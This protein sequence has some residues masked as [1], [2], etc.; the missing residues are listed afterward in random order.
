[1]KKLVVVA[2]ALTM[3]VSALASKMGVVNSQALLYKYSK[4][5]SIEEA[6]N[7]QKASLENQVEQKTVEIKKMEIELDAKKD[8]ITDAEKKAY[9]DKVKFAQKFIRDSEA[10]IAQEREKNFYEIQNDINEAVKVIAKAEKIDFVVEAGAVRYG[11]TNI[12]DKVL[13]Q[14]EKAKK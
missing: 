13:V 11:G 14:M 5:K 12:T 10:K 7:K 6:L 3:S 9:T 2:M 4:T 8:K 1:M